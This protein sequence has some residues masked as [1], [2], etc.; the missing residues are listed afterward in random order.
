MLSVG[1]YS[2]CAPGCG[3]LFGMCPGLLESTF[4]GRMGRCDLNLT[5]SFPRHTSD[6]ALYNV[7]FYNS[8]SFRALLK[9]CFPVGE[10]D[11]FLE[12]P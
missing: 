4:K 9:F 1:R 11:G 2:W 8:V 3:K 6:N 12:H 5:G 7:S 10:L